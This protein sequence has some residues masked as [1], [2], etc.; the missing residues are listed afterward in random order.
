MNIETATVGNIL[1]EYWK[2]S[3]FVSD[4]AISMTKLWG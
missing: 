1:E 2:K 3:G 4:N